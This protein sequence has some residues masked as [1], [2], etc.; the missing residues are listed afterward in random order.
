MQQQNTYSEHQNFQQ[1]EAMEIENTPKYQQSTTD[2]TPI[3][4]YSRISIKQLEPDKSFII[5][6]R[7]TRKNALN[8]LDDSS[9]SKNYFEIEIVDKDG[10]ETEV[11]FLGN[12]AEFF[13]SQLEENRVYLFKDGVVK[14]NSS[15]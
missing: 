7:I 13:F 15:R 8:K 9:D 1:P 5:K 2:I 12:A 6:A 11:L 10:N 4:Q 14:W 3:K